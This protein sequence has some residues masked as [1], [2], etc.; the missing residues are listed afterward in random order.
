M[1]TIQELVAQ[2]RADE[3]VLPEF[4]RGYVW[5]RDQ[6]RKFALALY[7]RY[8]TGHLLIWKTTKPGGVRGATSK[9]GQYSQLLLDGQQ[10]LTTLYVFFEGSPPPFYGGEKLFFELYFNVQTEEFRFWQKTLM[11]GN[12]SWI[13]V[14]GFLKEGLNKLLD[15]LDEMSELEK[16]LVQNNLARFN[17]LDSIRNYPYQVDFLTS[18]ELTVKD[19]VEIFNEVNSAGTPLTKADLAL[20]HMCTVWPDAR[21]VLRSFS[22]SMSLNGF[23]IDLDFLV[24]CI[25]AV[26]SGSVLLEG[27]FYKVGEEDL[28]AAWNKVATS[29]EYLINVLRH[30]A[31][32]DSL[33]DLPTRSV[34]LPITV[35]LARTGA[36]FRS[37]AQQAR[38]IRWM[39]LA[40]IWARYSGATESTLQKDVS[41]LD[42]ADPTVALE[43]AI[44]GE[45]GRLALESRDIL[46]KGAGA[47]VGKMAYVVARANDGKDWFTGQS[48]YNK[49][50]GK[51]SGLEEHHIFPRA[52]LYKSGYDTTKDRRTVNEVAN[53]VFL[54]KVA[55]QKIKAA[56][57]GSYLPLVQKLHP[58]A[59]QAHSVPMDPE[60]WEVEN[61]QAFLVARSKL[62]A[63]QINTF[64]DSLIPADDVKHED[65]ILELISKGES[66]S[67]EFKSSLRCAILQDGVE[68]ASGPQGGVEKALEKGVLKTIAGFLNAKGGILLIGVADNGS[69]LGLDGDYRSLHDRDGFELHLRQIVSS[70]VGEAIHVF[71]T[72]T[73]HD[74]AGKDVCQVTVQPSD[75]PVYAELGKETIFYLRVGNATNSLAVDEAVKYV[76]TRWG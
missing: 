54:A 53:R 65:R 30:D 57:P 6:V 41:L 16:A 73:F 34:L 27:S 39:F 11:D 63:G 51:S 12:P 60:L 20:A 10:R 48:L 74:M 1:P 52:V 75:H 49:A 43:E 56:K 76:A 37:A 47:A 55:N 25:A 29:F 19:V 62:L 71:V 5:T 35:Y 33:R 69:I 9:T 66:N 13:S 23:G 36:S 18:D 24:R 50:V 21:T 32:I 68:K 22:S 70:A 28:K 64:L 67:L 4:Q 42:E 14:Q 61:Y 72:V 2:I 3:I 58:G 7:R 46:G 31:Y 45:R 38:F 59:L 8:P 44:L 15:R 40:G 26:A 17:R